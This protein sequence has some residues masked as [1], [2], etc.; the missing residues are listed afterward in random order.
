V[1]VKR[2]LREHP[3]VPLCCLQWA[4]LVSSRSGNVVLP[5]MLPRNPRTLNHFPISDTSDSAYSE[6]LVKHS[7][8]P[9]LGQPC[10][11]VFTFGNGY[12]IF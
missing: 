3:H 1:E 6:W 5:A 2:R 11:A 4:V 12:V 10:S 7:L 8:P 9:Y